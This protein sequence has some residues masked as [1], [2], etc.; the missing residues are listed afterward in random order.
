MRQRES[1]LKEAIEVHRACEQD[2]QT[3]R[4]LLRENK[5]WSPEWYE[6]VEHQQRLLAALKLKYGDFDSED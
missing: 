2:T 5:G 3:L 1:F 4:R 6:V